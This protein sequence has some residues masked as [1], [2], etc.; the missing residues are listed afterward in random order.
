MKS[1]SPP[2]SAVNFQAAIATL[3]WLQMVEGLV[4]QAGSLPAAQTA[5]PPW[6]HHADGTA[7]PPVTHKFDSCSVQAGHKKQG[8]TM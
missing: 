6:Q 4:Q 8:A 2:G 5:R 7:S 3:L 1:W